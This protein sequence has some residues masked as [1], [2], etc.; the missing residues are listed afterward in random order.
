VISLWLPFPVSVNAL[1]SGKGRRFKSPR[2]TAWIIEAKRALTQQHFTAF[3][4]I[5]LQVT[6]VLSR[7]DKRVRDAEN[8]LKA[9]TDLLV[10]FGIIPDDS[11]IGR[12]VYEWADMVGKVCESGMD[13]EIEPL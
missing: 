1:Y 13:I 6:Y 3:D 2:Y 9:P 7:P 12:G 4:K 10:A 8:Y 11:Y 5:P